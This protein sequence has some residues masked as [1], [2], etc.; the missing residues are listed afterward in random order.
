MQKRASNSV[1]MAQVLNRVL[2]PP[3]GQFLTAFKIKYNLEIGRIYFFLNTIPFQFK[4]CSHERYLLLQ[5]ARL[6]W[7]FQMH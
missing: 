1:V 5:T 3:V 2:I 7:S 6:R 4:S